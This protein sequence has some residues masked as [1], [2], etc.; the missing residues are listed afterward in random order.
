MISLDTNTLLRFAL[1]DLPRQAE[2]VLELLR[3]EK[4][5][6]AHAAIAEAVFVLQGSYYSLDRKTIADL[7]GAIIAIPSVDCDRQ[8]WHGVLSDYASHLNVSF[9]DVLLAHDA[10]A[11][12]ALP[13]MTFDRKLARSLPQYVQF[14]A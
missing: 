11:N 3:N 6:I 12:N 14:V 7:L 2:A 8:F 13:L 10:A 9:E 4:C 5:H 1:R